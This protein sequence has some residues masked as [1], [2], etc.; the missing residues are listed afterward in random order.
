[1]FVVWHRLAWTLLLYAIPA[2]VTVVA[3]TWLAKQNGWDTHY[4]KFGPAGIERPMGE[5]IAAAS[6]AQLGFWIP[7]IS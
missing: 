7:V 4:T 5:T 3:F 6:L 1:M 2:R